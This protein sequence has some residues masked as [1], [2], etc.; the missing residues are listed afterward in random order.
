MLIQQCH[1]SL[2]C[3]F[4]VSDVTDTLSLEPSATIS[5]GEALDMGGQPSPAPFSSWILD[6]PDELDI[7]QQVAFLISTLWERAA[8]VKL[9][10][11]KVDATIV[12]SF[13]SESSASELSL[14]PAT[15]RKLTD[16]HVSRHCGRVDGEVLFAD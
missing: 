2:N 16:M 14:A 6:G 10:S 4:E 9:F 7:N 11:E 5:K 15:L 13:T 12:V 8:A 3:D 1:F